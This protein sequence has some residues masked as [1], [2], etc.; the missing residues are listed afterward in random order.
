MIEANKGIFDQEN[1]QEIKVELSGL[2]STEYGFVYVRTYGFVEFTVNYHGK[3]KSY[4]SVTET[5]GENAPV[6]RN[7][8]HLTRAHAARVYVFRS[9]TIR[10]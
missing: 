7:S 2:S 10:L 8:W 6:D 5:G 1:G 4:C 3:V 9:S